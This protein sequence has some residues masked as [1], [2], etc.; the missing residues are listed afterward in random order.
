LEHN[1]EEREVHEGAGSWNSIVVAFV[2]CVVKKTFKVTPM[3]LRPKG[4]LW[5][6]PAPGFS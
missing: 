6:R 1:R 2:F 4:E 3:G 5:S